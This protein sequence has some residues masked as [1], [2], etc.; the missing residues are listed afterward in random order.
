MIERCRQGPPAARVDAI[1]ETPQ[2]APAEP[3]FRQRPTV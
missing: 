2:S 3:G 1:V